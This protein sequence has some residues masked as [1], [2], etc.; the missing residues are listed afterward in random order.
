MI[1]EER[2]M[3][4]CLYL[5]NLGKYKVA[6]NPMVGAVIVY[7]DRIIGEG[8]H[9]EYG[10]PHAEPNAINSVKE[11]DKQFLSDSTL[12]VNLEPCSHYGKTAPCA[13]LIVKHKIKRVVIATLDPNPRV[14]GRGLKILQDAGVEVLVGV[15]EKE[16]LFL[17]RRFFTFQT[18]NRPFI[19]LKWAQSIDGFIDKK[20]TEPSEKPILISNPIT[21]KMTHKMRAENMSIMVGKNT[22]LLDNPTLTVRNWI[23]Q[24][25][26]RIAFDCKNEI[27]EYFK[28][29]D[30]SVKS[31]ILGNT[32]NENL[33]NLIY[34]N[35]KD[36]SYLEFVLK[37]L[38]KQNIHSILVEGGFTLL[39]SFLQLNLWDEINVEI[40]PFKIYDGVESPSIPS[41]AIETSR[42][43]I[44]DNL[45]LHF[46][47]R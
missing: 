24:S 9:Q 23:G 17:N 3:A 16:A 27:P 5:A 46:E 45:W 8:Y 12:Y 21:Q 22:V 38:H 10:K 7:N 31:I 15:L 13:T 47:K 28:I 42:D 26:I 44:E 4:R 37:E 41:N 34:L 20:R 11:V 30:N 35:V 14:A 1:T 19:I 25:P 29:K 18:K 39:Q 40:S 36:T 6:P 2:F 33:Q 43:K 32:V